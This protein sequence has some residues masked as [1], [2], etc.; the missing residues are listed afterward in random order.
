LQDPDELAV[1]E[2]HRGCSALICATEKGH[3]D[4][5]RLLLTAGADAGLRCFGWTALH[6][7]ALIGHKRAVRLLVEQGRAPL[8]AQSANGM[9]PL[10]LAVEHGNHSCARLLRMYSVMG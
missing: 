3:V 6:H 7:A 9:T 5:M 10:Q 8:D 2:G 1:T 4:L